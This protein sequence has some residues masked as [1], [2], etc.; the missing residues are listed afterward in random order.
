VRVC[1]IAHDGGTSYASWDGEEFAELADPFA[2]A[3]R[4][5][6]TRIPAGAGRLLAPVEPRTVVGMAHNTG[7]ADRKRPPAAFLK[8]AR[9]VVGPGDAVRLAD[10]G[11]TTVAEGEL[12]LVIGRETSGVRPGDLLSCVL[13]LTVA[14]DITDR[15]AQHDDPLWTAAKSRHTFTPVGPWIETGLDPTDLEITVTVNGLEAS[16]ASTAGLARDPAE[17]L[18]FVAGLMPLGPGD[19]VLTGAPGPDAPLRA[20]DSV[21]VRID[22]LG[23]IGNP[24]EAWPTRQGAAA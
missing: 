21:G 6:G 14:N 15:S 20:G 22:G 18:A 11:G 7:A 8:A 2:L 24:V 1:R 12:A 23:E 10:D 19:L 17:I 9:T 5:T 13:G 3:P 16:R 4:H